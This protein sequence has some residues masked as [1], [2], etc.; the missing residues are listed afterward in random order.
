MVI[1]MKRG[2]TPTHS[3]GIPFDV[4]TLNRVRITYSQNKKILFV[5]EDDEVAI[6]GNKLQVRLSQEETLMC[7]P[8]NSVEIQLK[9]LLNDGNVLVSDIINDNV[10]DCID[11][12]V[13]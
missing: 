1:G 6:D 12:E 5:K 3:F 4:E 13:L 11:E 9:V 7:R 8:E 10:E 2:T